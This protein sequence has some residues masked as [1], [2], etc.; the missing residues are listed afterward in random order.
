MPKW[1]GECK[2]Q[3]GLYSHSD[4]MKFMCT[5]PISINRSCTQILE[6]QI[7][8]IYLH[9]HVHGLPLAASFDCE[10]WTLTKIWLK[11]NVEA[12]YALFYSK[13]TGLWLMCAQ[14]ISKT[15]R[16]DSSYSSFGSTRKILSFPPSSTLILGVW[17]KDCCNIGF[18]WRN[19]IF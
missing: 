19:R 9:T 4:V 8:Q 6:I 5:N 16:E 12:T 11:K 13:K 2:L 15:S 14:E 3:W 7:T 10:T 1:K 18:S 17:Y